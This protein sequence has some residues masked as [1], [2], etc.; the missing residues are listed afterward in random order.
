MFQIF[1]GGSQTL[2]HIKYLALKASNT[3]RTNDILSQSKFFSPVVLA[4]A[5]Y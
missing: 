5:F 2:S 3:L 4:Q 1:F